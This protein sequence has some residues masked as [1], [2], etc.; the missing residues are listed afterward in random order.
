MKEEIRLIGWD[1]T[2]L[3]DQAGTEMTLVGVITRGGKRMEGL[4]TT[5]ILS[6]G[7]NATSQIAQAIRESKHKDQLQAILLDGITYGGFNVVDI[8]KLH[9]AT[10]LPVIAVIKGKPDFKSFRDAMRNLSDFGKRWK[11][12]KMAGSPER[13]TI[14]SHPES[15][16]FFQKAGIDTQQA[17]ELLLVSITNG[18]IPE[19]LRLAHL[20]ATGL[21]R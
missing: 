6:D 9:E 11:A 10:S 18:V 15:E 21:S 16:V 14:S 5:T 4:V 2:S 19:P 12:V 3:P 1:D 7:L 20:I 17:K 8:Q 13:L